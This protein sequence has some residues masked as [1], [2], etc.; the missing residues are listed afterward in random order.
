[1]KTLALILLLGLLAVGA[2]HAQCSGEK[3]KDPNWPSAF[4]STVE[5]RANHHPHH[6]MFRLFWD[7]KHNR[8]RIGTYVEWKGKHYKM[9]AL[10][11]GEKK[12][13]YY[14]F[15]ERD[16][17]KCFNMELKK[18]ITGID[19]EDADYQGTSVVEYHP[20]YHWEKLLH[21]K[22]E[23]VHIRVFD[24][25]EDREIKKLGY[26]IPDNDKAGTMTFHELNYGPQANSL[27][28][29]PELL[30]DECNVKLDQTDF[31]D[32]GDP[33]ALLLQFA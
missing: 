29:I 15:Y 27:F 25:Q 20:V 3:P 26:Y 22:K 6:S 12:M 33:L 1:M 5:L 30:K 9:E 28:K 17:V 31:L 14:I 2:S 13:A 18:N 19:L 4:S 32:I 16:Q 23:K 21:E 24:T 8:A 7:E 11:Y 10:Y